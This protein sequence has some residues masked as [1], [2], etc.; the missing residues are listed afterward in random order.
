MEA[1][2]KKSVLLQK[3][4]DLSFRRAFVL[5]V[6][7]TFAIV[8]FL[9]GL[10]IWGLGRLRDYL[11]PEPDE[12]LL[13]L[14]FSDGEEDSF[15]GGEA[16]LTCRVSFGEELSGVPFLQK[17]TE[18]GVAEEVVRLSDLRFSVVRLEKNLDLVGPRRRAAYQLCGV[19]MV[20]LPA[21]FSV[22]GI[23]LCGFV[24]YHDKMD[25]PIALL[26]Q[27][28]EKIVSEDLDFTLK[29]EAGDEMGRLCASFERM[30]RVL[31]ENHRALWNMLEERRML[32]A[33]VAHDLR[34]PIAILSGYIEYLQIHLEKD[35]LSRDQLA[36]IVARL[37]DGVGRLEQYTESV[38]HLS[39]IQDMEVKRK[40]TN[41]PEF[42]R[43]LAEDFEMLARE[44]GVV[45]EAS[46]ELPHA[47]AQIDRDMVCRIAENL[48]N[49]AIRFARGRVRL[50]FAVEGDAAGAKREEPISG[51]AFLTLEIGDDGPGFAPEVLKKKKRQLSPVSGED[52][53]WGL[54][55][56]IAKLLCEKQ[57]G[58]LE[59]R[60]GR[61]EESAGGNGKGGAG[62][63]DG[64]GGRSI[65][66][67]DAGAV[68]KAY[69]RLW[70]ARPEEAD[71]PGA[72]RDAGESGACGQDHENRES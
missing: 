35:T 3:Y 7:I 30:R 14:E 25:K 57:G 11:V 46:W 15:Q 63:K 72:K 1:F 24:F 36:A 8:A 54:G 61:A 22:A 51:E 70:P 13:T 4:R 62:G 48:V 50:F 6:L 44:G 19:W 56:V 42:A 33:S 47:R 71:A 5:T 12:G 23:L 26:N 45:L 34:N 55:L 59:L 58:R 66:E 2:M 17:W 27:A 68:A 60:N 28:M 16:K 37:D 21:C 41:L 39:R 32:Q 38:R 65:A 67:G 64:N 31:R 9:S 20:F 40:E 69:I 53:H 43:K 52:G 18:D 29:Y 10:G 49:N